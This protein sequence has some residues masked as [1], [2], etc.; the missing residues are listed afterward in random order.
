MPITGTARTC[1]AHTK[2]YETYQTGMTFGGGRTISYQIK[3]N[4][5][6]SSTQPV[7]HRWGRI[8]CMTPHKNISLEQGPPECLIKELLAGDR[9]VLLLGQPGVGKSTLAAQLA[10]TMGVW[11]RPCACLSADPGS[12]TFG[13]PGALCL[14]NWQED[15][16]QTVAIEAVCTLDAGRFRLPLVDA[17]RRLIHKAPPGTLLIDGPGVVRGV[18]GAELLLAIAEATRV[19][20][21]F[22]LTRNLDVVPLAHELKAVGSKVVAVPVSTAA[23]RP[24]KRARAKSRTR[25][26]DAYL[27]HATIQRM[28]FSTVQLL[29]IPPPTDIIAA[30]TGRQVALLDSHHKIIALGEVIT[31]E[32]QS[33]V[34]RVPPLEEH[35]EILLVRDAQRTPDGLLNTAPAAPPGTHWY[36]PPT[37]LFVKQGLARNKGP[38]PVIHVGNAIATLV[39]GV[40]GDPL[41]HLRMQHQKRSLLFDLGESGRLPARV[42]HQI[43]D[44]FISHTHFDH[45]AGFL[46]LLRSRIEV[47]ASCR[48]FG[49]PGLTNNIQGLING[50]RWDRIGDLG[51]RFEVVELRD[52]KLT[53][54]RV[55]AGYTQPV[56]LDEHTALDGNILLKEPDFCVRAVTLDHGTPVL[57]YAFEPARTINV[58]KDRLN[59]LGLSVGPWLAE[60]KRHIAEGNLDAL[61]ALPNGGSQRAASLAAEL[62]LIA[63]GKK[64][65]Y[66]TDLADTPDNRQRL[67]TLAQAA[68]TF[69]CEAVFIDADAQQAANTRHL[70]ARACGE[71]AKAADV[72]QLI[73]FHFSKRYEGEPMQVYDEVRA[74]CSHAILPK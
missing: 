44:V 13:V 26:W 52:D 59:T 34:L 11:G 21:V 66:A 41:L 73:P 54:H 38:R 32:D 10:H 17:L 72:E 15:G 2:G 36:T 40:F 45:I 33:L 53:S 3:S 28:A 14:G 22:M 42:A 46:W 48:V 68:H 56:W 16:W 51:P 61:I 69:F 37:D 31:I 50:I 20:L 18:A 55:Q 57:A 39:N 65:V 43:T 70:T 9:R 71:I 58:R 24:S 8:V 27:E 49:P 30:W 60:L 63:P 74:A 25:L 19:D 4:T 67:I 1:T 23:H 47:K 6:L 12:P 7:V 29:G 35:S 5:C 64:L 62:V